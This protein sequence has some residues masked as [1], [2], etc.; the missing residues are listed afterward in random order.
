MTTEADGAAT[1]TTEDVT[2][3]DETTV[4]TTT[5]TTSQ[6]EGDKTSTEDKSSTEDNTAEVVPEEYAAFELPEGMELDEALLGKANPLMKE[7]GLNQENA[8]KAVSFIAEMRQADAQA[9]ATAHEKQVS[10]W[11]TAA[12]A[13]K[14]FGGDKFNE[15]AALA[16]SAVDKLGSPE[17]KTF[18]D[19]SGLGNHPEL[20]RMFVKV[21]KAIAEDDPGGGS[22]AAKEK[23]AAEILYPNQTKE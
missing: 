15:N 11:E 19:E 9:I 5:D 22:P 18:L 23:S 8:Q 13:D 6:T 12:K 14:E 1:S 21:G 17:L 10:E 16:R 3:G 4:D 20:V 2:T 7:L